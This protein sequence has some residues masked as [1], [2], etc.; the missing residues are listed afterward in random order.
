MLKLYILFQP[1][2]TICGNSPKSA[3]VPPTIN[4]TLFESHFSI[5][6]GFDAVSIDRGNTETVVLSVLEYSSHSVI[7]I[8]I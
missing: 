1:H 7:K 6:T 2:H 5:D 8:I 3:L 4:P